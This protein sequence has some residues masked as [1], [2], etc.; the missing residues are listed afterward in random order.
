MNSQTTHLS[1]E[2]REAKPC[3]QPAESQHILAIKC[4]IH[5]TS[6]RCGA[7][8]EQKNSKVEVNKWLTD[9]QTDRP[10]DRPQLWNVITMTSLYSW[11]IVL[12]F[13]CSFFLYYFTFFFYFFISFQSFF[14]VYLGFEWHWEMF[15]G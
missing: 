6:R 3:N 10:N 1:R 15:W 4:T 7:I 12:L 2:Q 5:R 14:I 9:R 13:C 11:K 8:V